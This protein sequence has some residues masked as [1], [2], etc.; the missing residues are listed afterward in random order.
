V[1]EN[2]AE[3]DEFGLPFAVNPPLIVKVRPTRKM[4][5]TASARERREVAEEIYHGM[6]ESVSAR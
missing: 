5:D 6:V 2:A 1:I 3:E 4:R